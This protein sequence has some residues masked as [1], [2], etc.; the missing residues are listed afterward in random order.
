MEVHYIGEMRDKRAVCQYCHT[1][2]DLPDSYQRVKKKRTHEQR[3]SGSRTVEETVIET[4][5]DGELSTK[6][7]ESLPPEIQEMLKI[8]KEKGPAAL[9]EEFL[10][11]LQARGINISFDS[12]SLRS[13]RERGYGI[14]DAPPLAHSSKTVFTRTEER[15]EG[16]LGRLFSKAGETRQ[17]PSE[18]S[19]EEI[20]RLAG[21]ALPPEE[22]RQC[23]NPKCGATLP[24]DA[25]KCS[26]C[27]ESL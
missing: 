12:E 11:K 21:G 8:L 27:G 6:D 10:Q 19:P 18:I 23:P 15:D 20:I 13:L 5:R 24:K 4:R 7:P 17:R 22:R 2:V 14:Y 3:L 9:D 26:W 16:F 25:E 1:E